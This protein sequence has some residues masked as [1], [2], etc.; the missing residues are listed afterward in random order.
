MRITLNRFSSNLNR[1]TLCQDAYI[2]KVLEQFGMAESKPVLT[3]LDPGS[4]DTLAPFEGKAS[5]DDTELYQSMIGFI[6]Y[7]AIQTR[8][9]IAYTDSALS[10]F[11]INPSTCAY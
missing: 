9:D 10:R 2:R 5:K 4:I 8:P 7:F 1:I 11:L 3:P 6:N